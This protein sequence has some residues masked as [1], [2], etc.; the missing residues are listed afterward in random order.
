[1][2]RSIN[3]IILVGNIGRD[4]DI[5]TTAAGAKVAHVSL[6][7]SRRFSREGTFEERTEWHRLTL[8]DRLAQ[9]AEDY[10]RKGDRVYVEGRME[11]D[12][13][14]RNGVTIPTA[15]VHVRELVLLGASSTRSAAAAEA[16]DEADESAEMDES[17]DVEEQAV[18]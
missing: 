4:P 1:M 12:S 16:A 14:E 5:Q 15:E 2:G 10:V 9:L 7:T 6:A 13:F 18:A 8:W 17:V 3:K 11:Y